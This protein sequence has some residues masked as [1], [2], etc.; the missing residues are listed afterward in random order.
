MKNREPKNIPWDNLLCLKGQA[1]ETEIKRK[2][3]NALVIN[4]LLG[5]TIINEI[6]T[7]KFA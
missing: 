6:K 7:L 5:L 1:V 2:L 3:A 4:Q